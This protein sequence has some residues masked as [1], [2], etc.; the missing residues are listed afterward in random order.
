MNQRRADQLP[1]GYVLDRNS[2]SRLEVQRTGL[3]PA[4]MIPILVVDDSRDAALAQG[5][6]SDA[7]VE[8]EDV[9]QLSPLPV[10]DVNV[11][12]RYGSALK[13][14]IRQGQLWPLREPDEVDGLAA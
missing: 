14:S 13:E 8:P 9:E 12:G 2:P 4:R 11:L 1:A 5:R 3:L 7:A 6:S 10:K